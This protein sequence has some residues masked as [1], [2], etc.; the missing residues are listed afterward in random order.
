MK[1]LLALPFLGSM[2]FAS[3]AK[4]I[5]GE[6]NLLSDEALAFQMAAIQD[7]KSE[8]PK[9]KLKNL[10]IS[11]LVMGCNPMSGYAHSRDLFYV[12]QLFK[13]YHTDAK[14]IETFS[15]AE[16]SGIN[17]TSLI[18]SNYDVFNRYKKSTG[19]KMLSICQAMLGKDPDRYVTIKQAIDYGAD[20]LYI[21]GQVCDGLVKNREIDVLAKAVDLIRGQGYPAGVGAH[22]IQVVLACLKAGIKPDF[23]FK[24]MHHDQY[25]SAHPREFRVEFASGRSNDHNQFHDNIFDIFP[26]QTVDVFKT[27]DV[28]L[29]GFKVLAGGSIQ[30]KDGFRYAFENGA[31][32][33]CVG[34]LDYNL[35]NDVNLVIEILESLEN[36]TRL[37]FA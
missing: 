27:I 31:D 32:F 15:L 29:F 19:S 4:K 18:A 25:W 3:A 9:G 24:T 21:N 16:K 33:I 34:M 28:P 26:E 6:Y 8:L 37:W 36:R 14:I 30:P 20:A 5:I 11:R 35:V 2:T 22:S 7:I 1:G 12:G 17:C 23:Y 10:Q 13:K